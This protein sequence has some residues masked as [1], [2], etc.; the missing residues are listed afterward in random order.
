MSEM[1]ER[2]ARAMTRLQAQRLK[3]WTIGWNPSDESMTS[4]VDRH[5]QEVA[6]FA[7]AAIEAM[8][9]PSANMFDAGATELYGVSRVKA[10]AYAKEDKFDSDGRRAEDVWRAMIDA[11]LSETAK[12]T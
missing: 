4:Y 1:V 9:E 6:D 11:A 8:R 12:A 7:R 10:I 5:W 3:S 2:V